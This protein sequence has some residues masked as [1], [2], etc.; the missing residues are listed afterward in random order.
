MIDFTYPEGGTPIDPD[1]AEGLR[2]THITTKEELDRWE[3]DNIFKESRFTWGGTS[4]SRRGDFRTAYIEALREAV[5]G[6]L[7]PLLAFA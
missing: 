5:Q 2:L 4:L 6:D 3:T 7:A 1:E